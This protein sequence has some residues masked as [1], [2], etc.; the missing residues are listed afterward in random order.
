MDCL[1]LLVGFLVNKNHLTHYEKKQYD[2]EFKRTIV[3]LYESGKTVNELCLEF[4]IS[5]SS[6][7]RWRKEY[8]S[9]DVSKSTIDTV[10]CAMKVVLKT[11]L[12]LITVLSRSLATL[13][14]NTETFIWL[15]NPY[16]FSLDFLERKLN[17]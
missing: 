6:V 2:N 14:I 5:I 4:D 16:F 1:V 10:K 17:F 15:P 7:N 12:T 8:G 11:P 13:P 3:S 9:A